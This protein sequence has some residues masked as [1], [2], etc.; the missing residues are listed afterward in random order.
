MAAIQLE[1]DDD[2]IKLNLSIFYQS[3]RECKKLEEIL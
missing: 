3:Q 2:S 1:P